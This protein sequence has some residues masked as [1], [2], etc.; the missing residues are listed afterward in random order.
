MRHFR[1]L[2]PATAAILVAILTACSPGGAQAAAPPAAPV[3]D[4][5]VDIGG[6]RQLYLHCAGPTTGRP[7]IVLE[8]GYHDSSDPWSLTAAQAPARGPSTFERLSQ[9]NR[10]CAY[11]RPGT[12]RYTD[13]L[14]LTDRST[15]VPMPRT[16]V[17]RS[18]RARGSV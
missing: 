9:E 18:V 10:V 13:P 15:P 1:R 8:S 6:G 14:A 7:T 17:L 11:D 5:P 2:A 12:F 16:G 3:V 4:G